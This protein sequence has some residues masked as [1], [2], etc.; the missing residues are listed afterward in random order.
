M[1]YRDPD[2]LVWWRD[3]APALAGGLMA[4][5]LIAV[6]FLA[7]PRPWTPGHITRGVVETLAAWIVGTLA[8]IFFG[9]WVASLA[10]LTGPE[11]IGGVKVI[12]AVI[13]W[14]ALPLA[15]DLAMKV[16]GKRAEKLG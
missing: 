1:P 9:P 14:R 12:V 16:A 2:W 5:L 7:A 11:A 4:A 15:A 10:H 3:A 8:G 13:G 6:Q